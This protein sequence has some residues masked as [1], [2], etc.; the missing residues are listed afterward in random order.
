MPY[1]FGLIGLVTLVLL[2]PCLPLL[3]ALRIERFAPPTGTTLLALTLN[4]LLGSVRWLAP[5][6]PPRWPLDCSSIAPGRPLD[7]ALD[8]SLTAAWAPC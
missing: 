5:L 3:H 2:A 4:A 7:C 6:M 8:G 1:L